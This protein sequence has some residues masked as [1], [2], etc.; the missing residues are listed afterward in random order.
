[1][2][3]GCLLFIS[4]GV[5]RDGWNGYNVLQNTAS[6]TAALD[7]GIMGPSQT[8]KAPPAKF[9]YLLGSDDFNPA[10]IPQDAFV[11]YQG[12]HGDVG[13]SRANVILPGMRLKQID[14][15]HTLVSSRKLGM[16]L[17]SF[18]LVHLYCMIVPLC[19]CCNKWRKCKEVVEMI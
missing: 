19:K 12:H 7:L 11:V 9:V 14:A 13:A 6:M 5:I 16:Y 8:T 17:L 4:S 1:M 2:Q 15:L 3:F 10:N 18:P